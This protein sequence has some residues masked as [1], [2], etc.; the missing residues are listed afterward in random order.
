[1]SQDH[2][3]NVPCEQERIRRAGGWIMDQQCPHGNLYRVNGDLSLSRA[4]GD[5]RYKQNNQ[6][7]PQDQIISC[8]PEVRT[9]RRQPDDEFMVI[10]CDGVWDVLS[11]Q[12]AVDFIRQRLGSLLDGSL[13]PNVITE[14][15]LD[16]CLSPDL[17][18]TGGLGGD[19]MTVLLVAFVAGSTS[20]QRIGFMSSRPIT[21]GW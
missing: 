18:K 14:G 10:A 21:A 15:L 3:P 17:D 16:I 2:K 7:A 5:L 9:F 6:L 20:P 8:T 19:N 13:R 12:E 4:I 1:M 11:S